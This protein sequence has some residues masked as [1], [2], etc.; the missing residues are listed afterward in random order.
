MWLRGFKGNEL[1]RIIRRLNF[2]GTMLRSQFPTKYHNMKKQLFFLYKR[3]NLKRSPA[4]FWKKYG[5]KNNRIVNIK[6][7]HRE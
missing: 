6:D 2:E 7:I 3:Y 4:N 1:Q 5:S